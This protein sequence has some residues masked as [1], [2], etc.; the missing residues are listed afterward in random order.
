MSG[1]ALAWLTHGAVLLLSLL[2]FACLA[3]AMTR[4]QED[5]CGAALRP[6]AT[7]C[8]RVAGWLLLALALGLAVSGLGWSFGLTA[9]SGHTSAA[10]GL[11]FIM[12]VVLSRRRGR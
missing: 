4:H 11:V 5:L 6:H 3:L 7:R 2:G 12:L 9:Y 1:L 10:A 8:I